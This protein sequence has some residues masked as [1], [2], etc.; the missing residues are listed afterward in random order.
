MVGVSFPAP[1]HK[2]S[3]GGLIVWYPDSLRV[4]YVGGKVWTQKQQAVLKK[5]GLL[6]NVKQE[7]GQRPDENK[8]EQTPNN[9]KTRTKET[10]TDKRRETGNETGT[11]K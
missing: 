7:H 11:S 4:C 6:T 1:W 8:N 2:L 3:P 5:Q 9:H 10:E